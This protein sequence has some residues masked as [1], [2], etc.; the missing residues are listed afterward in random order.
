[1]DQRSKLRFANAGA[2]HPAHP[3]GRSTIQALALVLPTCSAKYRPS[4]EGIA[5]P[6]IIFW[7]RQTGRA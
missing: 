7:G 4:R 2:R 5:Q 1:M 3:Y 6:T